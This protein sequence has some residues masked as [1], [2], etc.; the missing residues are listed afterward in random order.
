M[1]RIR[2][3][4]TDYGPDDINDLRQEII[5]IR[6]KVLKQ[7]DFGTAVRLSHVIALMSSFCD[8]LREG[9]VSGDRIT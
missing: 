8:L 1:N 6:D 2:A 3:A 4:E 5:E 9:K 7:N